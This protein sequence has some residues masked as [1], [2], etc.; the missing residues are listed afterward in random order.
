MIP[1]Q[2]MKFCKLKALDM[3]LLVRQGK[4]ADIISI[5]EDFAESVG[6][7]WCEEFSEIWVLSLVQTAANYLRSF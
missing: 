1:K 7:A 3:L 2:Q 5:I 4:Y 6:Y